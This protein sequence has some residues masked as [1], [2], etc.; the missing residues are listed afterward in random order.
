M[1]ASTPNP[2]SFEQAMER[3]DEIVARME[4]EKLPLEEMVASYEE[5]MQ[6]LQSC[7]QRIEAA[8]RRIELIQAGNGETASLTPFDPEAVVAEEAPKTPAR[9]KTSKPSAETDGD[10]RLF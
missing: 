9:R 1:S 5:G 8:R 6:L 4:V 2:L 10:I 7:R 3:L